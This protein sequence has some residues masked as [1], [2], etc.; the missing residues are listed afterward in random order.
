MKRF[1]VTL[2][3]G[4]IAGLIFVV[5]LFLAAD[6]QRVENGHA[7]LQSVNDRVELCSS[8]WGYNNPDY[9]DCLARDE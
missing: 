1:K 8:V 3:I 5:A 4:L 9:E 7:T 2:L 6:N